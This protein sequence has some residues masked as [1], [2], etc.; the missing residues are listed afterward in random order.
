MPIVDSP[1][2]RS[3]LQHFFPSVAIESN[4]RP[5]GQRLVYFCSFG[6]SGALPSQL[7]WADWDKVVLKVSEDVHPTVIARLEKEREILNSLNSRF[8]PRHG[9]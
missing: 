9:A 6:K 5:S 3:L 7:A 2:V 1:E 4:L 8:F